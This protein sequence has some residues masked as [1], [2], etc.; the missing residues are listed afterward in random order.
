MSLQG[1]KYR[2]IR[3]ME[4]LRWSFV[5]VGF[6]IAY[7]NLNANSIFWLCCMV[8]LPLT[9]FTALES[10]FLTQASAE[11]KN[12][13]T[14]SAYQIQS[15]FNN[16]ATALTAVIATVFSL[17]NTAQLTVCL[18]AMLFFSLSS[19]NHLIE[20]IKEKETKHHLVRFL[21]TLILLGFSIPIIA[22]AWP[23]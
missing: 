9:G 1:S 3:I 14:G 5:A 15:A 10:L 16:L 19:I 11:Y 4:W 17:G 23:Q 18:V 21:S 7:Q 20:F 2:W 12:R 22:T 8:M 13:E 6:Y